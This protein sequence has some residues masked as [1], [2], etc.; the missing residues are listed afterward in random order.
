MAETAW[1]LDLTRQERRLGTSQ[2]LDATKAIN[3]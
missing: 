1:G 3:I 2:G